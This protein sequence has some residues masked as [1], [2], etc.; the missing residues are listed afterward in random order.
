LINSASHKAF[1]ID[2]FGFAQG[3]LHP[4]QATM[5]K[6]HLASTKSHPYLLFPQSCECF[7]L[8]PGS[9]SV[10]LFSPEQLFHAKSQLEQVRVEVSASRVDDESIM[11]ATMSAS[12]HSGRTS[13]GHRDQNS[14][15][16]RGGG[17]LLGSQGSL[18]AGDY[19]SV[20]LVPYD[21]DGEALAGAVDAVADASDK[22]NAQLVRLQAEQGAK[23]AAAAQARHPSTGTPTASRYAKASLHW[24][25][26]RK[27]SLHWHPYRKASLHWHPYRKLLCHRACVRAV[28]I[29]MTGCMMRVP[30]P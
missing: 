29:A 1:S 13:L 5:Q 20:R 10:R 8:T 7:V 28:P 11:P 12:L 2:K 21:R 23:T 19:G 15:S 22:H 27:A 24:H 16:I 18:A 25:P 17:A 6:H 3:I 9:L 30:N 4:S 14:E 26:Y